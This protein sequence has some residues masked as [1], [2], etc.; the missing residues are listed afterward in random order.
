MSGPGLL[1]FLATRLGRSVTVPRGE[2]GQCVDLCEL[3]IIATGATRTWAN[4]VDLLAAAPAGEWAIVGNRP[5]N[6]PS[7]GDVVVWG[8]YAP[9]GIGDNGHCAIVIDA[10]VRWMIVAHQNYPK[11]APVGLALMGYGGV[12]GWMARR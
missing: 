9:L 2:G 7:A 8:A 5:D 11:G 4:A 12:K 3:W 10:D 6:A 1:E